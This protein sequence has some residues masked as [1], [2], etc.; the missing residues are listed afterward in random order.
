M[1]LRFVDEDRHLCVDCVV[2]AVLLSSVVH[3]D[4]DFSVENIAPDRTKQRT[5]KQKQ[6][7]AQGYGELL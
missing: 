2:D 3:N 7:K 6:G 1:L 4:E 5:K